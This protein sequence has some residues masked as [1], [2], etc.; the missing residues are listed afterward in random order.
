M[1]RPY[2][3]DQ[4]PTLVIP[5]P[6]HPEVKVTARK[7]TR[8]D[9]LEMFRELRDQ[10][11]P[12]RDESGEILKVDGEVVFVQVTPKDFA[13][14]G[15]ERIITA[16]EGLEDENDRP[17]PFNAANLTVLIDEWL[18]V[19]EE[20]KPDIAFSRY[21]SERVAEPAAWDNDPKTNG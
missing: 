5:H 21:I 17:I 10:R 1:K 9:S 3:P 14:R 2:A 12:A 19:K 20:G 13:I 11:I 6:N 8:R 15:L 4:Q 16:W 7:P 18:D